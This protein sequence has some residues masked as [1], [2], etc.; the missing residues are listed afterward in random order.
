M[1]TRFQLYIF[2]FYSFMAIKSR[3]YRK[4]TIFSFIKMFIA[5]V[6]LSNF[7]KARTKDR[8]ESYRIESYRIVSYRIFFKNVKKDTPNQTIELLSYKNKKLKFSNKNNFFQTK[9]TKFDF[10]IFILKKVSS[11]STRLLR[12]LLGYDTIRVFQKIERITV[13]KI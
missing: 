7:Q 6:I 8:I 10:L 3:K 2:H 5:T 1:I 12:V 13:K 9:T 11:Y 4:F